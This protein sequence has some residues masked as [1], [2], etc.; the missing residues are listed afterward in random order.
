MTHQELKATRQSKYDEL[1]NKIG[2]FWAFSNEQFT[3]GKEKHPITEGFKYVSIGMGGYF[4]GQ[5]KQEYIDGMDAIKAWEKK[6]SRELK[7]SRDEIE[8]AILSELNNHECFYS[9][10]IDD[11]VDL[12]KGIYTINQIRAVYR[13]WANKPVDPREKA[14]EIED[15]TT[16]YDSGDSTIDRIT[17]ILNNF[18]RESTVNNKTVTLYECLATDMDGGTSFSQFSEAEKGE[19][20]G[21]IVKFGSLP[22]KVQN[23]II[24]RLS[25]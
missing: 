4:P 22:T 18:H 20:L 3:E 7:K 23:H 15:N 17:V 14:Q 9:G 12:F 6:A 8:K 10:G 1:F 2:L 11:V 5:N 25:R 21:K 16:I 24:E 19:H 13:K